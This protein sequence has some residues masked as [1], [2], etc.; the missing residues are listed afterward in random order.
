MVGGFV[1]AN[2]CFVPYQTTLIGF[3]SVKPVSSAVTLS[4][5]TPHEVDEPLGQTN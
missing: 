3:A 4:I 1:T 2:R 5:D